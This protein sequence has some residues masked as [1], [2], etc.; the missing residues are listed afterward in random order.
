MQLRS[1]HRPDVNR[2]VPMHVLQCLF[3]VAGDPGP[4]DRGRFVIRRLVGPEICRHGEEPNLMFSEI[5]RRYSSDA[6]D[7]YPAARTANG[8]GRYVQQFRFLRLADGINYEP[9]VMGLKGLQI[10]VR[11]GTF[12]TP[13]QYA[14]SRKHR[15][16]FNDLIAWAAEPEPIAAADVERFLGAVCE[17]LMTEKRGKP[18][19]SEAY[20]AWAASELREMIDRYNAMQK[21]ARPVEAGPQDDPG[22]RPG[23]P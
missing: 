6:D 22:D 11:P 5:R 23:T 15:R 4:D 13:R 19:H 20:I 10:S 16:L 21:A 8:Q 9:I 14:Q 2:L 18:A 12:L 17:G 1:Q 7:I 3:A